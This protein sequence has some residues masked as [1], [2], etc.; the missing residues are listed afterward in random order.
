MLVAEVTTTDLR[1][2]RYQVESKDDISK[3]REG[4]TIETTSGEVAQFSEEEVESISVVEEWGRACIE[5]CSRQW[6]RA[7]VSKSVLTMILHG[8]PNGKKIRSCRALEDGFSG[9]NLTTDKTRL[10][11]VIG[12]RISYPDPQPGARL[13][14]RNGHPTRVCG[15][16]LRAARLE[17]QVCL[18][19]GPLRNGLC[20]ATLDL[21]PEDIDSE[22][23]DSEM[24]DPT[25][26]SASK[27]ASAGEN[28]SST[29]NAP[30]GQNTD[31]DPSS[32]RRTSGDDGEGELAPPP[33]LN[34]LSLSRVPL[35]AKRFGPI[36][37]GP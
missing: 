3:T 31:S 15:V 9:S 21:T 33:S 10:S 14:A 4:Y 22:I 8:G 7:R 2:T 27:N 34:R 11:V 20:K 25:G 29:G 1:K 30:T 19:Y 6:E 35:R 12:A 5:T 32:G 36:R 28:V 24:T 23:V 13:I 17:V 37:R 18:I 16:A 26:D